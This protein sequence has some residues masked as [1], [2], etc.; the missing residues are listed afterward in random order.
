MDIA[1]YLKKQ[2]VKFKRMTHEERYTSQE[3]AAVQHVPGREMVKAVLVKADKTFVLAVLPAIYKVNFKRLA[4]LVGAKKTR[5]ADEK[6]MAEVFPDVE[7]GAEPPFGNLYDVETVVDEHLTEDEDIVFQAGT[8][9]ATI[10]M[11]YA[12]YEKLVTPKVG[13]FGDH[14]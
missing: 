2:K 5:L 11:K 12:D 13:Q 4:K 8:H 3:I 9:K 10:R 6:D 14:I 7:V 1:S